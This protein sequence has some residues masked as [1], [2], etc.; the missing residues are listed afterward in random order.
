M[1]SLLADKQLHGNLNFSLGIMISEQPFLYI[2]PTDLKHSLLIHFL[3]WSGAIQREIYEHRARIL[4]N[5]HLGHLRRPHIHGYRSDSTIHLRDQPRDDSAHVER[6]LVTC[7]SHPHCFGHRDSVSSHQILEQRIHQGRVGLS[8]GA[9][10]C[11]AGSLHLEHQPDH[12]I[13]TLLSPNFE[14]C[15]G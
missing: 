13:E 8:S 9:R 11:S 12:L 14:T 15:L 6:A 2:N 3:W 5:A 10:C 4:F 7:G 1:I